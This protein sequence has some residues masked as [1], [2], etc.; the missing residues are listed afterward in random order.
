[1]QKLVGPMEQ[2]KHYRFPFDRSVEYSPAWGRAAGVWRAG[3]AVDFSFGGVRILGERRLHQDDLV[4]I[5]LE[6]FENGSSFVT[7]AR[8]VYVHLQ[9]NGRCRNGRNGTAGRGRGHTFEAAAMS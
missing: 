2:R 7:H 5:R 8:V 3:K 9:T 6:P 4:Q 1:M